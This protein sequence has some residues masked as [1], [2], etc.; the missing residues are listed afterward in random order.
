MFLSFF[1]LIYFP[2]KFRFK[3]FYLFIDFYSL[4]LIKPYKPSIYNVGHMK[5]EDGDPDWMSQNVAFDQG[6]HCVLPEKS[7]RV[8]SKNEKYHRTTIK[9]GWKMEMNW[10]KW[11]E[12]EIQHCLDGLTISV[13]HT[14]SW[15]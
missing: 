13:P 4:D 8:Q 10:S 6:L 12:W 1:F 5:T 2:F 11:Q 9:M 7:I 14:C 15:F 3:L